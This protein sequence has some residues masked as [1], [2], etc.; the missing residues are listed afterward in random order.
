[1]LL[2]GGHQNASCN[3]FTAE[4]LVSDRDFQERT[5]RWGAANTEDGT[6]GLARRYC[7][8]REVILRRFLEAHRID[9]EFYERK[10]AEWAH[11]SPRRPVGSGG[12]W[13]VTRMPT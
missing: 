2:A 9:Q 6:E 1:M 5:R 13:Y 12:D 7:V 8:S 4:L 10:V 11:E 3:R